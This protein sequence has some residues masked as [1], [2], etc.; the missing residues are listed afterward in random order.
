[1]ARH[2]GSDLAALL[3]SSSLLSVK[4][5][6]NHGLAA[7]SIRGMSGSHT[8]VTWNGLPV[9]AP[10]NG[11]TDFAIIPLSV[12]TAVRVT[13]GGSDLND[14]TGTIGGKIELSSDPVFNGLTEGSLTLGVGSYSNYSSAA[15]L[16]SGTDNSSFRLSL[17]GGNARN[18]FLYINRNAPGR[19]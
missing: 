17:W 6:G 1:M 4:R 5:Y 11:Y 14:I 8:L 2:E 18:D 10:G 13:S 16:R 9:N 19:A 3:H 7:V 12:A 15:T